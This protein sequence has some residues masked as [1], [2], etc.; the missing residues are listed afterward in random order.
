[1][2]A[3]MLSFNKQSFNFEPD[4]D[5]S[6]YV[7][8]VGQYEKVIVESIISSFGLDM[9]IVKDQH[10]GDVDTIHNVRKVGTDSQMTYKNKSNE[11][12]YK[13][14]GAYKSEEY[15]KGGNYQNR[16]HEARKKYMESGQTQTDSYTGEELH[17]LGRSKG[18][19]AS[20]NAELDHVKSA[21]NIHEDRGRILADISGVELANSPENLKFTNK[22]LNASMGASEI[23]EYLESHPQLEEKTKANMMRAYNDSSKSYERKIVTSYYTSSAFKKDTAKAAG[24]LGVRMGVRQALGFVFTEIWFSVKDE[25]NQLEKGFSAGQLFNA[26]GNGVKHGFSSAMTKY[27]ELFAKLKDGAIA[28][29]LSSLTTTLCNIFFT[30]AKNSIKI[31]RQLWASIVEAFRIL[32][33]NPNS[34][35][36]GER[37]EAT[38]KIIATGASVIAGA[39]VTELIEKTG[40]SSIPVIGEI[41]STFCGIF[42]TGIMTVSLFNLMD[43]S[44]V[45]KD[46]IDYLNK[47]DKTMDIAVIYYQEQAELF[48]NYA[49]QLLNIDIEKFESEIADINS[50]SQAIQK[51]K[52]ENE[53]NL[54]LK[55]AYESSR[56]EIPWGKGRFDDFMND[57]ART[58]RFE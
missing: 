23:P 1:M 19:P 45:V 18:A 14:Q 2:N 7:S 51:A 21:K 37:I 6:L 54:V 47:I 49:A 25:L 30:A 46:L 40:V 13:N 12:A 41:L 48:Q 20:K 24:K 39:M 9:L 29:V 27:K 38:M 5:D 32:M 56:I 26:I 43:R 44:Q 16:K 50:L 11:L 33:F 52:N 15:H 34:L 3:D 8:I 35:P 22:S 42:V 10:G 55:K 17:F 4:T 57:S 36:L 53:L 31:I 28:G 58:L